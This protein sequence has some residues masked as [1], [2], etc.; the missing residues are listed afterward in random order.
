VF[1][2]LK[3]V[4]LATEADFEYT[5]ALGGS[6]AANNDILSIMNQVQAI[7]ERDIGLTF[8][9]VFQHTWD[10]PNDPYSATDVGSAVKEFQA[11]WNTNFSGTARDLAHLWTGR[12]FG[13]INGV[14]YQGVVCSSP[15][16]AYGLSDL[17]TIAPF[18]VGIPAHEL[19][20]NFGATHCDGQ[21][22]CDN[23]IMVAV[24]NQSNTLSFCQF[25]I[26]EITNYVSANSSCLSDATAT[27]PIDDPTFFVKQHYLDF[28]N[29]TADQSGLDFWVGGIT[30]CGGNQG[31]IEAK[32][33]DTS[34]AFFLSIEFQQTGYLVERTYKTGFGDRAGTSTLG[35]TSHTLSVPIVRF[36]QFL[37]DTQTI[38]KGVVVGQ[39]DWQALLERNKVAYFNA[40]V[41]TPEFQRANPTNSLPTDYVH[42]L[43]VNAGS[44]LSTTDEATLSAQLATGQQSRAGVLR[45]IAEHPNLASAEFNRAFV[46]MQFFGYLRRN[47]DD[48]PDSDYSGYEFW[49]NKLNQFGDYKT[50]EMVKAFLNATE[51]RRRFGPA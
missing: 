40:F 17:E 5:N 23:T 18:R 27:N 36:N 33:I 16:A 8:K 48:A 7:Y 3:L 9:V 4:E 12:T 19:G 42:K 50:A 37:T 29:R 14:A 26:N 43:N 13:G 32:R 46:L 28:L 22:G 2:P 1:S 35:G 21:A 30:S 44:P 49:L 39:G 51:Y 11:Y 41:Q 45:T 10:T 6:A 38:G 20:H 31:C 47:P 25:S 15:T 34:A 24:Q